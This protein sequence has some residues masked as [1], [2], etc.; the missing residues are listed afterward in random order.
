MRVERA[1]A[2]HF[3]PV[4]ARERHEPQP[5]PSV[6]RAEEIEA[7]QGGGDGEDTDGRLE[8]QARLAHP[9]SPWLTHWL[10]EHVGVGR[11]CS[12]AAMA[13]VVPAGSA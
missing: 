11:R 8:R 1:K 3:S 2:A 6:S 7:A 13:D 4:R 10:L 12:G 5:R 9:G